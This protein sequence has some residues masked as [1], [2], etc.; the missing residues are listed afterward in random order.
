M[1]QQGYVR[2]RIV[3]SL[4]ANAKRIENLADPVRISNLESAIDYMTDAAGFPRP[5]YDKL[6]KEA[7][8]ALTDSF[9]A[10]AAQD[11]LRH[12]SRREAW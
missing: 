6:F 7:T 3:E 9:R 8:H 12:L 2:M 11:H 4:I 1:A 10:R 5:S